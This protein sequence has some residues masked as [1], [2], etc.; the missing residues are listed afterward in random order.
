MANT[1]KVRLQYGATRV[2]LVGTQDPPSV[3]GT[4]KTKPEVNSR[5]MHKSITASRVARL[6]SS[7]E[8]KCENKGI[9][10][11]CGKTKS[12]GCEP[13]ARDYVCNYCG[14]NAVDG[15][16]ELFFSVA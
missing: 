3:R 15:A 11:A 9:C 5:L 7:N 8:R 4:E 14:A 13:D 16:E 6:V 12:E 10:K 1:T 2:S